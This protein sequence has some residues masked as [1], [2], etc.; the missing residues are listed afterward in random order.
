[1]GTAGAIIKTSRAASFG[2][3]D[4]DGSIAI[5]VV[6]R[7]SQ[8]SL[9]RNIAG[10]EGNWIMFR[11]VDEHNRDAIG[12][13]VQLSV[14]NRRISRDVRTAYSYCAANDPRVHVGLGS[15]SQITDVCVRWIDGT[16]ESFGQFSTNQITTLRRGQGDL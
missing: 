11:V 6:N 8:L 9:L 3:I 4:N 1:G 5:V 10:R 16:V 13:T 2:D 7:D 14:G 12:A 15:I